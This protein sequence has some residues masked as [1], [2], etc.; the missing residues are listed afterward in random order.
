MEVWTAWR[1]RTFVILVILFGS[2]NVLNDATRDKRRK[3]DK[4]ECTFIFP[5]ANILF[6]NDL[7][8]WMFDYLFW[9]ELQPIA[10]SQITYCN[11]LWSACKALPKTDRCSSNQLASVW[12]QHQLPQMANLL[13][14]FISL[15]VQQSNDSDYWSW[16]KTEFFSAKIDQWH[17]PHSPV[18]PQ[19]VPPRGRIQMDQPQL[20]L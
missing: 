13:I 20:W 19:L 3:R 8:R 4:H 11:A 1:V 2:M 17:K 9:F 12:L 7:H 14:Y 15:Y 10:T 5:D 16:K 18:S 6:M